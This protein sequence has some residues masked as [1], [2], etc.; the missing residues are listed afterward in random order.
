MNSSYPQRRNVLQLMASAA[1]FVPL[2]AATYYG[3]FLLRFAGDH[4][5]R[6]FRDVCSARCCG[7]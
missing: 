1:V 6:L 4:G 5:R 2:F 7:C 3:A